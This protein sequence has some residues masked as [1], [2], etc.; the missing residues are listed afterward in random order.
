MRIQLTDAVFVGE[1]RED[2]S[3]IEATE[4]VMEPDKV[5]ETTAHCNIRTGKLLKGCL[6]IRRKEVTQGMSKVC[7]VTEQKNNVRKKA[8][9]NFPPVLG[10][11]LMAPVNEHYD[12]EHQTNIKRIYYLG[13]D[14]V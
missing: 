14:L 11:F 13:I 7:R 10:I 8:H 2:G 4:N 3:R 5:L 1:G 9:Y 12:D 6:L